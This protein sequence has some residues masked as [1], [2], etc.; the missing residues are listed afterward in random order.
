M[1]EDRQ[2]PLN[3]KY[4]HPHLSL[5]DH[6]HLQLNSKLHIRRIARLQTI[7]HRPSHHRP[8]HNLSQVNLHL[9]ILKSNP[10]L[11][12]PHKIS[13]LRILVHFDLL[14]PQQLF[15]PHISA[16]K[17]LLSK[18]LPHLPKSPIRELVDNRIPL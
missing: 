17:P 16:P 5:R 11:L 8:S 14:A 13:H 2:S 6:F 3:Y 7:H 10:R 15:L 12:T 18:E 4:F 1:R 9:S